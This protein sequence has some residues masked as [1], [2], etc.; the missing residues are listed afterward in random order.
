MVIR[1]EDS[2]NP[3]FFII[4]TDEINKV[5]IKRSYRMGYNQVKNLSYAND[6]ILMTESEVDCRSDLFHR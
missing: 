1:Q 2:F 4:I 3:G 5:E 6:V